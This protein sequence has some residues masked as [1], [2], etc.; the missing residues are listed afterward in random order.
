MKR[1]TVKLSFLVCIFLLTATTA[2]S[3]N[4]D[5]RGY[6]FVGK[7]EVQSIYDWNNAALQSNAGLVQF[8]YASGDYAS[9]KCEGINPAGV[10]VT[11][12]HEAVSGVSSA[13]GYD[14]RRNKQGQIT[15]FILSGLHSQNA[16]TGLSIGEC[17]VNKNW[18]EQRVQIGEIV[19]GGVG[20][21][22][23]QVSIDSETWYDLILTF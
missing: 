11:S 2:F 7:G 9:W 14:A 6:G 15:G 16:S 13:V 20:E 21:P 10:T 8:R 1:I 4:I 12:E 3:A 17:P 23:L 22:A 18:L 19:Y 5:D